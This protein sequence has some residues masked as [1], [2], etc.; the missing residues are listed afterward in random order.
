MQ[1][2]AIEKG[3]NSMELVV[4]RTPW[5]VQTE[6]YDTI[7]QMRDF[8]R[9]CSVCE[10]VEHLGGGGLGVV[11]EVIYEGGDGFKWRVGGLSLSSI[12]NLI[13]IN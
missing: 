8:G 4:V 7:R 5:F 3:L 9:I 2:I 13:I 1:V 6:V 10:D 11:C 12:I